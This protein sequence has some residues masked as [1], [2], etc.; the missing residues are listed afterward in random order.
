MFHVKHFSFLAFN[1]K[2]AVLY[3]EVVF[4]LCQA[5]VAQGKISSPVSCLALFELKK[6]VHVL[7]SHTH[8]IIVRYII[9]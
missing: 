4:H 7:C 5:L 3:F 9:K 2:T 1:L 8:H 6:E